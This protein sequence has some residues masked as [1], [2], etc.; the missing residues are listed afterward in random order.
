[1]TLTSLTSILRKAYCD[2]RIAPVE[3]HIAK[4]T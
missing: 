4:K 3:L 2:K 1:M